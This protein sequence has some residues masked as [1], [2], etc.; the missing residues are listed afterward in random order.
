MYEPTSTSVKY[1]KGV[2][3]KRAELFEKLGV[4]TVLDLLR[5]CPRS[6]ID[7]S[8]PVELKDAPS[9]ENIAV[10]G[11]IVKKLPPAHIRKGMTLFKAVFTDDTDDLTL[12]FYNQEYVFSSLETEKEYILYGRL[13]G[14][15][16]R[17]EMNSPTVFPADGENK[18]LPV[19][20]LTEGL[21]HKVV[22]AAVRNALSSVPVAKLGIYD[23]YAAENGLMDEEKAL[24][25]VHFPVCPEE[26]YAARKRLV[27]DELLEFSIELGK[28]RKADGEGSDYKMTEYPLSEIKKVFPFELTDGQLSAIKDCFSDMTSGKRMNRLF[29]G[30]VGCG[31]TAAAAAAMWLAAKNGYQSCLMA[32][33]E[34]LAQQHYKTFKNY[35]EPLGMKVILIT[36]SLSP[37]EKA[38]R[39]QI[40]GSGGCDMIIG[41]HALFADNTKFKSLAL[42]VADE[43][44]RFGVEQRAALAEKSGKPH[45]LS[46]TATPIPRTLALMLYGE[47]SVSVIR[48]L[49]A[50]RKPVKTYAVSGKL[51]NR[52]LGYVKKQLD[53]GRQGYIVCPAIG[54]GETESELTQAVEYY[55]RLK[56]GIFSGYSVGLLHGR[57]PPAEKKAVMDAFSAG[58]TDLLVTTTVVEVGVDVPSASV[59][60][61]ENAE[62]FGLSQIHQ[63]RGRV[64]RGGFDSSCILITDNRSDECIARMKVISSAGDGFTIAEEDLKLRGPGDL[65]GTQQHG[66]PQFRLADLT[67]DDQIMEM[68]RKTA[69]RILG[70]SEKTV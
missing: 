54:D 21:S 50:G 1:I 67:H 66:L 5:F 34:V 20:P 14:N 9:D 47:T 6:Y 59:I 12:V 32:P 8:A 7:L 65:L 61:I 27:F 25:A 48:E 29:Q 70:D 36:G 64:G 15:Y 31:K 17:K 56:N 46:M 43:Q 30:D 38:E 40:A 3:P 23:K 52:A 63:L 68:A 11:R 35:F 45:V 44:H 51:R 19:Y 13:S 28:M 55:E 10:R 39:R 4:I 22:R 49:P 16:L 58:K 62:R 53:M 33:T 57:M 41:T 60:V 69:G 2:G 37:K 42:V 18:V 26:A 24:K